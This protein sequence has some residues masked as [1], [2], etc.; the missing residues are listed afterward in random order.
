[1]DE[2]ELAKEIDS[3]NKELS[4]MK[5]SAT[6]NESK[7]ENTDSSDEEEKE[8]I[9]AQVIESLKL[10]DHDPSGDEEDEF[11]VEEYPW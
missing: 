6:G 8:E 5:K 3:I 11:K 9:L 2:K 10:E 1:M 4:D 7:T